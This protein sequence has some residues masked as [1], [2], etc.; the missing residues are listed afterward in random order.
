MKLVVGLGNPG[1]KYESTRH[2]VGFRIVDELA[3]KNVWETENSGDFCVSQFLLDNEIIKLLKPL[4]FMND[5][6][7]SVVETLNNYR[8]IKIENIYVIYDDLDI[9]LGQYKIQKGKGPKDHNGLISIYEKIGKKDFW[10]VRIG[11]ENSETRITEIGTKI[12]GED[13][14]L[15]RFTDKEKVIVDEVSQKIVED[16]KNLLVL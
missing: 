15:M 13:Y 16:L 2:N 14:V 7:R 3:N 5:S 12:A 9:K 1:S 4:T 6:G 11:I 8:E 10:H